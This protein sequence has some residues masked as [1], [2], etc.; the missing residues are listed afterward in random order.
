MRLYT[1]S[2]YI[3]FVLLLG[4][5]AYCREAPSNSYYY[6][7]S[8]E[9]GRGVTSQPWNDQPS[10]YFYVLTPEGAK[11]PYSIQEISGMA[12]KGII[13]PDTRVQTEDGETRYCYIQTVEYVKAYEILVQCSIC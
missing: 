3:L 13:E 11:G 12:E 10:S 1:R 5:V 9:K 7:P 4:R 6:P 2:Q 8:K